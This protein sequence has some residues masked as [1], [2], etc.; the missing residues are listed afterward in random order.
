MKVDQPYLLRIAVPMIGTSLLLLAMGVAAAMHVQRQHL[1]GSELIAREIHSLFAAQ[2]LLLGMREI[3][4][5]LSQYMRNGNP[6]YLDD[7][8]RLHYETEANLAEAGSLARGAEERELIGRVQRNYQRFFEDFRRVTAE[9]FEGDR[10]REL[11]TL[12]DVTLTDGIVTQARKYMDMN[13]DVVDFTNAT[14]RE[15]TDQLRQGFLLLGLCGSAAGLVA[16]LA[17]ARGVSQSIVQ[18]DVSV[19]GAAGKLSEVAGPV[20]S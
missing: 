8:A 6:A 15:A 13:R 9:D 4:H 11:A 17:I 20:K 1:I 16:G 5:I 12:F 14:S 18:L 10:Q 3:R 7:I 2:D 19:R